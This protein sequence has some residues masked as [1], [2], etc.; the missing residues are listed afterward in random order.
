M[1][2]KLIL[3]LLTYTEVKRNKFSDSHISSKKS[4]MMVHCVY[5]WNEYKSPVWNQISILNQ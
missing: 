4:T 2:E 5:I 3:M 1:L